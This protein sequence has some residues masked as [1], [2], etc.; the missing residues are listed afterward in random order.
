MQDFTKCGSHMVH[1]FEFPI[2]PRYERHHIVVSHRV[3]VALGTI[4]RPPIHAI[5]SEGVGVDMP[6][7]IG[8]SKERTETKPRSPDCCDL[9]V[10]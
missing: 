8:M 1:L 6:V 10:I 7:D 5:I 3:R 9:D 4:S 2:V